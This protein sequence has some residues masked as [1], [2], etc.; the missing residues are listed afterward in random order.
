MNDSKVRKK[1]TAIKCDFYNL[2]SIFVLL[3]SL[4]ENELESLSVVWNDL[5]IGAEYSCVC[6]IAYLLIL[7]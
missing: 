1:I 6:A 5:W 3:C 7:T 4:L 2:N